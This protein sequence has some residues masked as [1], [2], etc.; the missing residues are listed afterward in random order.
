MLATTQAAASLMQS[1]QQTGN[2][3]RNTI[4]T[5]TNLL[6]TAIDRTGTASVLAT[7]QAAAGLMQSASDIKLLTTNQT[8]QILMAEKEIQAELC[9]LESNFGKTNLEISKST[10]EIVRQSAENLA[11]IKSSFCGV[12]RSFGDAKLDACK[13]T[14][15]IVRQASDNT[16]SIKSEGFRIGSDLAKQAAD[17]ASSIKLESFRIGSDLAKQAADNSGNARAHLTPGDKPRV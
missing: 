16:S 3:A 10:S 14:G 2:D 5:S 17:N 4:T 13:N 12:E 8:N 11:S 1:I 7:S 9:R 6:S 15:E